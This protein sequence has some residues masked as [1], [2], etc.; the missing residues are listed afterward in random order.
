[1]DFE[2]VVDDVNAQ[3]AGAAWLSELHEMATIKAHNAYLESQV[4]ALDQYVENLAKA[5]D[6]L[7]RML[8]AVVGGGVQ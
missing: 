1:M 7:A 6:G 2:I 5:H 4:I 3:L 8:D